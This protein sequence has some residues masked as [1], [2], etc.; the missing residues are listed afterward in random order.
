M[1][2]YY[3]F[4]IIV[5]SLLLFLIIVNYKESF[6]IMKETKDC[7]SYDQ[8]IELVNSSRPFENPIKYFK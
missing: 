4:T 1:N 7:S 2:Y 8:L 6:A 3:Y 5:L